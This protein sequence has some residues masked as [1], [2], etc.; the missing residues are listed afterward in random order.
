MIVVIIAGGSGTRL[1]PLSTPGYPKH[2]LKVN[3]DNKSLL[4]NTYDRAKKL[5]NKIYVVSEAG[6]IHH[7]KEQLP[8]LSEDH[9]IVEPARRG[10]ASCIIAAL[11]EVAKSNDA[12]EPI[13]FLAADHYIRDTGGFVHSFNVA[14]ETSKQ[15]ARIVLVGVEPDYPAT[16][17]GY[18]QKDGILDEK[19][20]IF[21]VHSFKEKPDYKT[22]TK[23]VSS[24]NYLWNCGYFVGSVATFQD[25]M[26]TFAPDM[27]ANYQKLEDAK[28]ENYTNTY[29]SFE[30][31][32]IDYALI[33]KVEN[34][35]V[36]PASFD[37]M[38]LGSFAD[39][40]KA[41]GGDEQG[42]HIF[43]NNVELEEVENS[44]VENHEDKPV[45]VI[46]LDN[47][48][49]INTPAGILVARKDMSQKVGDVSKRLQ[50]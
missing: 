39:I 31:I 28:A 15:F 44:F 24:G 30:S 45:A 3:G 41:V 33:E 47:C 6:H 17:F 40:A 22:A 16:G 5:T 21:N 42:N 23:Y 20:F 49:V 7:V 2:L 18:I 1:W 36:V 29:L 25:A 38:D 50:Q 8:E 46:G 35:L 13:A 37:W 26:K 43:G 14:A 9:F 34:L 27:C 19:Q 11:V 32:S 12:D 4:Q 48:V 10:T